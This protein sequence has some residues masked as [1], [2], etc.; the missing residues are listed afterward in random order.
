MHFWS[1]HFGSFLDLVPKLILLLR[2][3]LKSENQFYFGPCRRPNKQKNPTWLIECISSMLDADV[4]NNLII[5]N[6]I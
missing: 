3:S 1:L 2:R 5:K 6:F 4:A